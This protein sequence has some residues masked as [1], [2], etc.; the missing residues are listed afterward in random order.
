MNKTRALAAFLLTASLAIHPAAALAGE[1]WVVDPTFYSG[2][3]FN[4]GGTDLVVA[5]QEDGKIVAA[6]D[7]TTYDGSPSNRIARLNA[8]GSLDGTFD[9][10]DGLD[11]RAWAVAVQDDGKV[12]VGGEF[13]TYDGSASNRIARL[14]ADG[15]LDGTFDVGDGFD[16]T[17]KG[18]A[19]QDDGKIVVVGNFTS[20]D[21]VSRNRIAR[22][23]ADGTLD[24]D[25]TPWDGLDNQ[26]NDLEILGSGQILV[27]GQ[28]TTASST[29]RSRIA[30]FNADGTHD[31]SFDPGSGFNGIVSHLALQ[32]DGKIIATGDFS[33]FNGTARSHI[34]RLNADG[35]I[36]GTFDPGS[37]YG[38][39]A[40]PLAIDGDG[41][42]VVGGYYFQFDGSGPRHL[43]RL[44]ADGSL[45]E[46]FGAGYGPDNGVND[47][48]FQ[49]DGKLLVTWYDGAFDQI[50]RGRIVRLMEGVA[51]DGATND[52]ASG[53]A[54]DFGAPLSAGA[55]AGSFT[56]TAREILYDEEFD[57][58][59]ADLWTHGNWDNNSFDVATVDGVQT[60]SN[61]AGT[62]RDLYA[63]LDT[64]LAS[65]ALP[66]GS[67]VAVRM[68]I[69]ATEAPDFY[70]ITRDWNGD[71]FE[72]YPP[73]NEW[74]TLVLTE[75]S[76]DFPGPAFYLDAGSSAATKINSIDFDW[77]RVYAMDG[78][79][80]L[81]VS[82]AV[83]D[84]DEVELTLGTPLPAG[85][86]L[87]LGYDGVDAN[88]ESLGGA[89]V[90]AFA[91]LIAE[92][93][94]PAAAEEEDEDDSPRHSAS[95]RRRS[96][97]G[98]SRAAETPAAAP[99]PETV[100]D[101]EARAENPSAA[102]D[103]AP[104]TSGSDFAARDLEAGATGE[105]VRALQVWLNAHGYALASDGPGAPGQ[106]TSLFG[107]LTR[108]ALARWQLDH[109]VSP[110][111]GYYGPRTR[112]AI[113]AGS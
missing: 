83:I 87:F 44:N 64:G 79:T 15:S 91:N 90:G 53:A 30:R 65:D 5:I 93:V 26:V 8:D 35:S 86:G 1:R 55:D 12:I 82:A 24:T 63:Y 57:T 96:S 60:I 3:G 51:P 95:G 81:G 110:A 4:G 76:A 52:A 48:A 11:A 77:V 101:E 56:A 106:E 61:L 80:D 16:G 34:A 78:D 102:D 103:L 68:R 49:N 99:A 18:I 62:S 54:V 9:V 66:A 14:N 42:I 100:N 98:G 70:L 31:T 38:G 72:I 21:S 29:S 75:G 92:Y 39:H 43:N 20:Y 94:A 112:A 73:L 27:V 41:K 45:D 10:G 67:Y 37:G 58:A 88:V 7:F 2:D 89:I 25:F 19:I 105:D 40:G 32:D 22:L 85:R 46:T 36:D 104:G 47:L 6:S 59:E 69:D 97:G 108:A 84:G 33:T 74:I 28:F 113:G 71:E 17:V 13:T 23:N 109:G 111:L 107:A 50:T